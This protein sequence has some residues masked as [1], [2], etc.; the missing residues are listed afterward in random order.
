[1]EEARYYDQNITHDVQRLSQIIYTPETYF[2]DQGHLVE[3]ITDKY[4]R[5]TGDQ[6]SETSLWGDIRLLISWFHSVKPLKVNPDE[7]PETKATS[8][9]GDADVK[10]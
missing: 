5:T 4:V 9:K 10:K 3:S 1:M 6:E 7:N 2:E 8:T